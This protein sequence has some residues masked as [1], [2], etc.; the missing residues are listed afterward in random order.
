MQEQND[1]TG[2]KV[3]NPEKRRSQISPTYS[4]LAVIALLVQQTGNDGLVRCSRKE[5][6]C[7][8]SGISDFSDP[9]CRTVYYNTIMVLRRLENEGIVGRFQRLGEAARP[10]SRP[11]AGSGYYYMITDWKRVTTML[12]SL[13]PAMLNLKGIRNR[14]LMRLN[15]ASKKGA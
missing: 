2:E 10:V 4:E 5:L 6:A 11:R 8:L 1:E 13:P 15:T 12:S 14:A 9:R 3:Q 7:Q